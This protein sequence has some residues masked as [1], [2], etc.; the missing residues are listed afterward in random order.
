MR[1]RPAIVLAPLALATLLLAC[2]ARRRLPRPLADYLD[3][4]EAHTRAVD[5]GPAV[6]DGLPRPRAR[7]IDIPEGPTLDV[8]GF[9]G[10]H[11]CG[12]SEVVGNR[13]SALG[14][15]MT[16]SQRALYTLRFMAVAERCVPQVEPPLR[17]TLQAALA[18]KARHLPADI[19][20]A[21][22]AGPEMAVL[23][24]AADGPY[25]PAAAARARR[26]IGA[27]TDAA[28]ALRARRPADLEGALGPLHGLRV[29]GAALRRMAHARYVLASVTDRLESVDAADCPTAGAALRA[30][31]ERH[32]VKRAQPLL[33]ENDR[34]IR[35]L[36]ASLERLYRVTAVGVEP[37][38]ALAAFRAT[39]LAEGGLR[40][41][42]VAALR[43]HAA[44]WKALFAR[45]GQPAPGG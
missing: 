17:E 9:L 2:D 6:L 7:R 5:D 39:Y 1:T 38:S 19:F 44:A 12:L 34:S 24:S 21:V 25:D 41:R 40:A 23:F 27:L 11:A 45:C 18:H 4:V 35:P 14:R 10:I 22:W 26:S 16:Y 42:Y 13:N 31:F 8:R 28:E 30:V 36:L 3:A 33:A 32:Y 20:N 29:A 15:V 43:A 37:P